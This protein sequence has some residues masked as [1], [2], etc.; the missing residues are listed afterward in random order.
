M[1]GEPRCTR[2]CGGCRESGPARAS[3]PA[4]LRNGRRRSRVHDVCTR[5][6]H[7]RVGGVN[8]PASGRRSAAR[9]C[10]D[11]G[12]ARTCRRSARRPAS[13][14]EPPYT[15][16]ADVE[17]LAQLVAH[18]VD[19]EAGKVQVRRHALL[20]A[21]DHRQLGVALLG[22]LQQALRLVEQAARSR[23]PGQTRAIGGQQADLGLRRRCL[24]G[25]SSR[26]RWCRSGG[27]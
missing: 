15:D 16:A 19:D 7:D 6:G 27:R 11:G 9:A 14:V 21:A 26:A 22:L 18:Q 20:D 24:H 2:S 12:R 13:A 17:H 23:A 4:R 25:R 10:P 3:G 1:I 5:V 8:K